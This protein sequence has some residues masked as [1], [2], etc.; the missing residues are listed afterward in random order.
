MEETVKL[1]EK[2]SNGFLDL[3][4]KSDNLE[5]LIS[6]LN[7]YSDE[8]KNNSSL[9]SEFDKKK[10]KTL[11][12]FKSLMEFNYSMAYMRAK[13]L[14]DNIKNEFSLS[15]PYGYYYSIFAGESKLKR[16]NDFIINEYIGA[17]IDVK[18]NSEFDKIF[19]TDKNYKIIEEDITLNKFILKNKSSKAVNNLL[20]RGIEF[21]NSCYNED[22]ELNKDFS[23]F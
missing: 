10:V 12:K 1:F 3:T 16:S 21:V 5:T 13:D 4:I 17:C 8:I 2:K 23:Y 11:K 6:K 14:D 7:E 9:S 19:V 22:Y 18:E 20:K 15:K